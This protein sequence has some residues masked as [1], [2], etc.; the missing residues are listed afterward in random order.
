MLSKENRLQKKADF[1]RVFKLGKGLKSS[2]LYIKFLKTKND[3][4]RIGFVVSKEISNKSN[5]RNRIKRMLRESAK[6]NFSLLEEGFDLVIVVL[7]EIKKNIKTIK[8][9]KTQDFDII[10]VQAFKKIKN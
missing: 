3:L 8:G 4:T 5:Q 1:Q 9:L 2:F 6:K 7:P 10:T